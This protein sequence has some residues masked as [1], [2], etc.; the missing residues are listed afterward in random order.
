[1]VGLNEGS[2]QDFLTMFPI[3]TTRVSGCCG[4]DFT[5]KVFLQT[6]YV[7]DSIGVIATALDQFLK[8]KAIKTNLSI[9][10][11]QI[12]KNDG[13]SLSEHLSKTKFIGITGKISFDENR[14]RKISLFEIRNFVPISNSNFSIDTAYTEDPWII[15]TGAILQAKDGK[16]RVTHFGMDKFAFLH[17]NYTVEPDPII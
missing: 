12:G 11:I 4:E 9:K 1:M 13:L 14:E 8:E 6:S 2:F 16:T 10:E 5:R 15:R 17:E 3:E 7:Y